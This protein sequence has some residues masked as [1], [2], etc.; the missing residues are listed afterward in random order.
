MKKFLKKT[1]N[2]M[3]EFASFFGGLIIYKLVGLMGVV[4]IGIGY[5]IYV[6][7]YKKNYQKLYQ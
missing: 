3:V 1:K 6:F 2:N 4:A 7:L 5:G